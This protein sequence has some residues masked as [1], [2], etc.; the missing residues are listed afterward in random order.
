[1]PHVTE[2]SEGDVGKE[3]VHCEQLQSPFEHSVLQNLIVDV[4]RVHGSQRMACEGVTHCENWKKRDS[5][6]PER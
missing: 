3:D 4:L 1:M 5:D 6:K 2:K